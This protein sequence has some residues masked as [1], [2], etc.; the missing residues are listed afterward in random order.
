[1]LL[2]GKSDMKIK[3][4]ETFTEYDKAHPDRGGKWSFVK[5][6]ADSGAVGLGQIAPWNGADISAT[7]L[8]Q[9]ISR[10]ALGK[11]PYDI[12]GLV[13]TCIDK[14]LKYPWSSLC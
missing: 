8:Y 3:R 5:V 4:I 10:W 7:V 11:D 2:S 6:T 13:D 14:N 1:M 12:G 9:D